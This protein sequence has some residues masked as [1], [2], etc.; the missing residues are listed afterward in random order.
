M[1]GI[2][3][4]GMVDLPAGGF[5]AL[6]ARA[7]TGACSSCTMPRSGRC[8]SLTLAAGLAIVL[9]MLRRPHRPWPLDRAHPRRALGLRRLVLPV[10][11]LCGDQLGDRL[12]RA[13]LRPAGAAAGDRGAARGGLAFDR[14]DIAGRLGLLLA[15]VGLVVYPL[16]PPLFGR[17]GRA[18]R[19]SAS[20][21]TRRRSRR[22]ASCLR[23]AAG[24]CR[25]CFRSRSLW[26]L[27]SG[28]TLRTMGDP[29]AWLPL[30]AAGIVI[31][32]LVLRRMD[33]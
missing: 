18:R 31:A 26:L 15:V 2:S 29:Q 16:L 23:R 25:C 11:P 8:I 14:R 21:R 10:E 6:L 1:S 27:L 20:R 3:D 7:S 5:P 12:C 32:A 28:L 22:S 17:P 9:L 24:L 33:R 30:L 4:V 19:S 13:G